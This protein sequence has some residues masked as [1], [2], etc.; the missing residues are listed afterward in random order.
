MP[1]LYFTCPKC[2]KTIGLAFESLAVND[3]LAKTVQ[4]ECVKQG[5]AGCGWFGFESVSQGRP[6]Q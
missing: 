1:M 3:D 2:G 6:V 5:G 4:L